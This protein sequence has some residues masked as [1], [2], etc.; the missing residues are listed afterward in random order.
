[1]KRFKEILGWWFLYLLA[2][3]TS[4]IGVAT[5]WAILWEDYILTAWLG[6][7]TAGCAITGYLMWDILREKKG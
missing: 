1:M 2:V 3:G 5:L 6:G 7:M 4:G